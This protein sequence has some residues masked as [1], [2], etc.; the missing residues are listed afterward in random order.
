M[1]W[2]F[3]G[4]NNFFSHQ[5]IK[6]IKIKL[7]K[8]YPRLVFKRLEPEN[9]S[10]LQIRE[11]LLRRGL[12]QDPQ[13]LLF[14]NFLKNFSS[15]EQKKIIEFLN[16]NEEIFISKELFLIFQ[17][18]KKI[19]KN[20]KLFQLLQKKAK[21]QEFKKL[22]FQEIKK[23]IH[24]SFQKNNLMIDSQSIEKIIFETTGDLWEINNEISKLVNYLLET[25]EK[26][27]T[28]KTV[29]LLIN[30]KNSDNIFQVIEALAKKETKKA[31]LLLHQQLAF[32]DNPLKIFSMYVYQF[33]TLLKIA[34]FYFKHNHNYFEIAQATGINPFVVQKGIVALKNFSYL[35]LKNLYQKFSKTDYL[36]KS[37]KI[38]AE[39]ALDLLATE[40]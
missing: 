25:Q 23:W 19:S 3:Y 14:K 28:F 11:V 18:E 39:V 15:E 12:F 20:N 33:R 29:D 35:E 2:F 27:V 7:F 26:K 21:I 34:D 16:K 13:L 32:G 8:K 40:I 31:L 4:E 38:D 5:E 37:G 30:K 9:Y 10:F 1:I 6:K 17:E 22:S 36:I 24:N